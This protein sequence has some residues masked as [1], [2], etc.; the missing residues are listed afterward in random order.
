VFKQATAKLSLLLLLA[1]IVPASR[2]HAQSTAST[3][4][5]IMGG[6]PEPTGEPGPSVIMGGDPEPTGEPGPGFSSGAIL[7]PV[8][9]ATP[10]A[11]R[12]S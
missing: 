1:V 7:H 4:S 12:L 9:S 8:A 10:L 6:D 5:V 11:P 3:T 2:I